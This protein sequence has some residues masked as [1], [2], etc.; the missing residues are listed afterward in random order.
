MSVKKY[1]VTHTSCTIK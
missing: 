1:F